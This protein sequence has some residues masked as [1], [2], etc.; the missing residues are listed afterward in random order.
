MA[1]ILLHKAA[2]ILLG[3]ATY[4]ESIYL[5]R[6]NANADWNGLTVFAAGSDAFVELQV[7]AHHRN[8]RQHIRAIANQR[9]PFDGRRDLP[10]F[11]HV[12]FRGRE[13]KLAVG[14]VDLA[15]AEVYRIYPALNRADN[16]FRIIVAGQHIGVRHA[17]HGNVLVALATSISGIGD[18]HEACRQL[19]AQIPLQN[20][21][22][23]ED[24]F[25]RGFTFVVDIERPTPPRHRAIVK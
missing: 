7:V 9:R 23:D 4:R 16:I 3:S 5:D 22:L 10:T 2:H 12:G 11:N 24:C 6:R 25:L 8:P 20:A 17:W 14:D 15:A 19:V 13:Y 21:L 1:A 18:S